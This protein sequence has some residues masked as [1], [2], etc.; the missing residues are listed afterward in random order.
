MAFE[1]ESSSAEHYRD[2]LVYEDDM[3]PAPIN[4][5]QRALWLTS[6]AVALSVIGVLGIFGALGI[7]ENSE[8]FGIF[9]VGPVVIPLACSFGNL[10]AKNASQALHAGEEYRYFKTL[11]VLAFAPFAVLLSFFILLGWVAINTGG[12]F[13]FI[14]IA[15]IPAMVL[16]IL[17]ALIVVLFVSRKLLANKKAKKPRDAKTRIILLVPIT[18][19]ACVGVYLVCMWI[20]FATSA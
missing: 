14:L 6:A 17:L 5:Y 10:S 11:R 19:A 2:D 18:A 9:G 3:T 15:T 12:W 1:P 13:F 8:I 20:L 4:Y 7:F 16:G